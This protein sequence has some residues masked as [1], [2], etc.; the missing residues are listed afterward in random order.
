MP[1][2]HGSWNTT[3]LFTK[4][5][6]RILASK[7]WRISLRTVDKLNT[8]LLYWRCNSQGHITINIYMYNYTHILS[9]HIGTLFVFLW[10]LIPIQEAKIW[11][12]KK[13]KGKKFMF[14]LRSLMLF[15]RVGSFI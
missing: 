15:W 11:A 2:T 13:E 12:T 3:D 9:L 4:N 8:Y 14:F 7:V 6:W 1:C 10:N 5:N